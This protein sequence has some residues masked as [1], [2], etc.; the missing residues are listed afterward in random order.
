MKNV[1]MVRALND[2]AK[3]GLFV[4]FRERELVKEAAT[5][6]R[7]MDARLAELEAQQQITMPIP[8]SGAQ[9]PE[10]FWDDMWPMK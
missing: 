3:R 9:E 4:N 2:F 8:A 7:E 10:P 5:R 6:I 1:D